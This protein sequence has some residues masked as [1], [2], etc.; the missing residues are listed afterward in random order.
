MSEELWEAR[1]DFWRV[2]RNKKHL[3]AAIIHDN[4]K[5][6]IEDMRERIQF[7]IEAMSELAQVAAVCR[8]IIDTINNCLGGNDDVLD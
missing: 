2:S 8:K 3:L 5:E 4:K 7:S 1:D 6:I